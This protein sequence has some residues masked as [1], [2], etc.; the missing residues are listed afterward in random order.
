MVGWQAPPR[1]FLDAAGDLPAPDPTDYDLLLTTAP[2][3]PA[4]W[5]CVK[6][7]ALTL[8]RL[9]AARAR[10]P[11]VWDVLARLLRQSAGLAPDA[12]LEMESLAFSALQ[13]GAVFQ[14]WLHRRGPA[15]QPGPAPLREVWDEDGVRLILCDPATRNA[16][17]AACRDALCDALDSC[18]A[19]PRV[20]PVTLEAEGAMFSSGGALAE[21]GLTRDAAAAH[22]IR[23]QR[24]VALRLHDLGPRA[25]AVLQGPAI[26]A[27]IEMATACARLTIARSA[28]IHLPELAMGLIP[29]AG[30]TVFIP[31]RIGRHRA[32]YL[33]VSGQRLR[34]AEAL[35]WG[36]ADGYTDAE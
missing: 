30:G 17:S 9:S 15:P 29:G 14:D 11:V 13:S 5:V 3:A 24:S 34:A 10:A 32:F 12:A 21:F 27:G 6:D 26:G 2:S 18:L 7:P 16:L 22:L 25:A 28:W 4:P 36:L 19:D 31:R 20:L 1:V 33:M 35:D 8:R 23:V